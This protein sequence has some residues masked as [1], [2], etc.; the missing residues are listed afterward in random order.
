MSYEAFKKLHEFSGKQIGTICL[1]VLGII[2]ISQ[3]FDDLSIEF[4]T[5]YASAVFIILYATALTIDRSY[6]IRPFWKTLIYSLL[7]LRK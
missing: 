6:N 4:L 7:W 5:V 1:S 2:L 3:K